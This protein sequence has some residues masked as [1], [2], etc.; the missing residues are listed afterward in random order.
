MFT[1]QGRKTVLTDNSS[2]VGHCDKFLHISYLIAGTY[3]VPG[4]TVAI[5]KNSDYQGNI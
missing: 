1:W 2:H 4:I 3:C 5:F